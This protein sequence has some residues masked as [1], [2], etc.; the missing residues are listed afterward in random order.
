MFG[1]GGA[2][3]AIGAGLIGY[4]LFEKY[5][6]PKNKHDKPSKEE[7]GGS[8]SDYGD[9]PTLGAFSQAQID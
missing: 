4:G 8:V 2:V 1:V 7:W 5:Y 3:V 6:K 9:K